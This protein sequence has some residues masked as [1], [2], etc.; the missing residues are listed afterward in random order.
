M[1]EIVNKVQQSGLIAVD[2]ADYL[3][4]ASAFEAFDFAPRL[5]NGLVLK[6]KDFRAFLSEHDW[7]QYAGKH[8]Y[9]F[10][11]EEAILPSWAFMIVSS[12][13]VGIAASVTVGEL[14]DARQAAMEQTI[15][16]L[17]MQQFTDG[18]LI[19]KGCSDIPNPEAM[20]SL[21]LQR[22]QP[23]CSSIMYGEPCSTVPIYKKP[24][25]KA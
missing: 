15:R 16:G 1:E 18:K 5:W 3:P 21:F 20:M 23:V 10:C 13:L 2:L 8:V 6:E 22:V 9:L 7:S 25:V 11:S 4:A 24:K 12:K 17:D 14:Q 19:V